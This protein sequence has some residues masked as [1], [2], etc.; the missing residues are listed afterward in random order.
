[1][2]ISNG[3]LRKTTQLPGNWTTYQ[4]FVSYPIN[5]YNVTLN[6]GK[7]AHLQD[8][9]V[10]HDTLTLD[11]YVMPYNLEKGK[12]IFSQVKPM[13][14][15][16]ER[17]FGKYPF[18]RDGF[19]LMESL[20]PMEHQSAVTFGRIPEREIQD[21]L[22]APMSLVWHEVAHE[23][24]GNN[25]GCK[26]IADMWIHE[27]FAVYSE[28][29]QMK[30]YF[31]EEGVLGYMEG[32]PEQ[33]VGKEPIIGVYD[34]NH[35]HYNIEDMYSKGALMLH[36]FRNVLNNEKLWAEILLG[37]QQ[38]FKY[39]TLTS[40]DIIQ[41]INAKTKT[42]YRYFFNQYLK[43]A[44]IPTL[45]LKYTMKGKTLSVSYKW[46]ADVK[47]FRMPVKVT[48]AKNRY[49]FIYPTTSWQTTALPDMEPDDFLVDETRFYV[50]IEEEEVE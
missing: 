48:T 5:N 14:A 29:L 43:Y 35:I 27:A 9:Y 26:D 18:P 33:V 30:A 12:V 23:W 8:T 41:Y 42:D 39:K 3:R 22:D 2:N 6:I 7:Y 34:V 16:L 31:G 45:S 49:D 47:D 13:L 38:D 10:T 1:M 21:S 46:N 28:S 44:S 15:C 24:W 17:N 19:K 50:N 32:L 40:Q 36:T 25:V 4:W 20:Y 37:I 11:Y